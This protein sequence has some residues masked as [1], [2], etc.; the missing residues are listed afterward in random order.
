MATT[1][2]YKG[3]VLVTV[4]NSTKVL[5]TSG[6]WCEDDFTLV[7]VSGGGTTEPEEKDV[8]FI[9]YDGTLLYSY[10]ADEFLAM[11]AL[12]PNPSH[13]GLVAQ[14]W[15]WTLADA[16][17]V[18]QNYG[19][20]VIGQNYTTSD[21][22]TRV[23]YTN[24]ELTVGK[25][26]YISLRANEGTGVTIDWGDGTTTTT[27]NN[28]NFNVYEHLYN[29]L[30]DY[31]ISITEQPN[32]TYDLGYNG[33]NRGAF[34]SSTTS[35]DS[36]ITVTNITK[37][38][39]GSGCRTLHRQCLTHCCS[40]ESVS[41]PRTITTFGS[42]TN[43]FFMNQPYRFLRALVIPPNA[44]ILGNISGCNWYRYIALPNISV[45][46]ANLG[47]SAQLRKFY[48]KVSSTS[49]GNTMIYT[50]YTL[51]NIAIDGTY[52][53]INQSTVREV[54]LIKDIYVPSSVTYIADYAFT[55]AQAILHMKPTTPPTLANVRGIN[56]ITRIIVPYSADH[57]I[58][59]AYQTASNWSTKA[60]IMVEESA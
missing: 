39:I 16:K 9:D 40:L 17:T 13:D 12:P 4:D 41:I 21:G 19:F 11:D 7:D 23:Y 18:V 22:S 5:E 26:F 60:S 36:F 45:P 31:V 32:T 50:S 42:G 33:S 48:A 27:A 14:G 51:K 49:I 38:E 2:Q 24:D 54:P 44:E 1:V 57:S 29:T 43:S 52:T 46:N 47:S 25:N 15:N 20:H 56:I 35:S 6:T 34:Y 37:L 58:L 30:G 3:Q 10:T 53:S 28:T 55:D 8:D 59:D